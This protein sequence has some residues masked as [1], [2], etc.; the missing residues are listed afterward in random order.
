MLWIMLLEDATGAHRS[1]VYKGTGNSHR[2]PSIWLL[3]ST[4]QLTF[5]LSTTRCVWFV[6]HL[7]ALL[8]L[9]EEHGSCS[10]SSTLWH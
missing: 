10:H 8:L 9:E 4:N 5:Q 1:L 7:F 6:P 2:T 3:P